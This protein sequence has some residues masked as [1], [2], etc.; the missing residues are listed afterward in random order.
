MDTDQNIA[1]PQTSLKAGLTA[2][3]M[4]VAFC[5]TIALIMSG[6]A[7]VAADTEPHA[8]DQQSEGT[9]SGSH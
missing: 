6:S 5:F 4:L 2:A 7:S 9:P 1:A 3:I 8:T